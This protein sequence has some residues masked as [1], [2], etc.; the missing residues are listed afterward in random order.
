MSSRSIALNGGGLAVLHEGWIGAEEADA[1]LAGLIVETPWASRT[2][3]IA[4]REVREPRLTAWYG[5]SEAEYTYSGITLQPHPWT[6]RLAELRA[7]V[8]TAA[9][10]VFNSVLLNYYRDERDSMGLHADKEPELGTNP[11]IASLS[12]GASRRFILKPVRVEGEIIELQLTSGSLVVMSGTTQHSWKH[13][14]PKERTPTGARVNL[15]F[16]YVVG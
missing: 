16:R 15:T 8:Q 6:P 2:I 14:V 9:A 1:H 13:G 12:F 3:R 5:D 10:S 11:T 7:R 4:G